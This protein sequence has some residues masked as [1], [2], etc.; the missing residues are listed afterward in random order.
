M[1]E[2]LPMQQ[3][4]LAHARVGEILRCRQSAAQVRAVPSKLPSG[5]I[6][7][8]AHRSGRE[9][10]PLTPLAAL[11]V[12]IHTAH[13]IEN[14]TGVSSGLSARGRLESHLTGPHESVQFI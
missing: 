14:K 4:H 8:E 3:A 2:I 7:L 9:I 11:F 13:S 12:G 5:F 6:L 1:L 10:H